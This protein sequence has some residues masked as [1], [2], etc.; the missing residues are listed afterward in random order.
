MN[1]LNSGSAVSLKSLEFI[2]IPNKKGY[3]NFTS[4]WLTLHGRYVFIN[5]IK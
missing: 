1:V 4:I 2:E 3:N 5:K